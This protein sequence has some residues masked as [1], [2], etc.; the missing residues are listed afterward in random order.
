MVPRVACSL[1]GQTTLSR[2][3]SSFRINRMFLLK[4]LNAMEGVVWPVILSS[5]YLLGWAKLAQLVQRVLQIPPCIHQRLR[6]NHLYLYGFSIWVFM[7]WS[8]SQS[9]INAF[10]YQT[11]SE[12][13]LAHMMICITL[14]YTVH[15]LWCVIRRIQHDIHRPN[16]IRLPFLHLSVFPPCRIYY[17]QTLVMQTSKSLAK[18]QVD[19]HFQ[20]VPNELCQ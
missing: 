14:V 16:Q 11:Y 4:E 17:W 15:T 13:K 5:L 19:L 1:A 20:T 8:T 6:I 18:S 7:N 3:F 10:W 9:C 2:V 12:Q